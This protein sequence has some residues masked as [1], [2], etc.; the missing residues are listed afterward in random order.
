MIPPAAYGR[1][2]PGHCFPWTSRPNIVTMLA[3][4]SN[5]RFRVDGDPNLQL[6]SERNHIHRRNLTKCQKTCVGSVPIQKE[7]P[8]VVFEILA[9]V[10]K[11]NA[12]QPFGTSC[13]ML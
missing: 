1:H 2:I 6:L 13:R 7:S 5:V 4:T 10:R 11:M 12:M 3:R 9:R 8:R